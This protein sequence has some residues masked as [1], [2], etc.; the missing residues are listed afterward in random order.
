MKKMCENN[1]GDAI[2]GLGTLQSNRDQV[3][4]D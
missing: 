2:P 1:E 4:N 3:E